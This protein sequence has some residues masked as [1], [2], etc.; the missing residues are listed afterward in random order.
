MKRAAYL[1]I[2]ILIALL[3]LGLA[4]CG[5]MGAAV[6]AEFADERLKTVYEIDENIDFEYISLNIVYEKGEKRKVVERGEITGFDTSVCG[7]KTLRAE[8][9][10]VEATWEYEVVYAKELNRT[11]NTAARVRLEQEPYPTGTRRAVAVDKADL[12][13]ISAIM[14]TINADKDF[15][16]RDFT[17]FTAEPTDGYLCKLYYID[18]KT[19]RVLIYATGDTGSD[20]LFKF[21]LLGVSDCATRLTEIDASDGENDYYL[22]ETEEV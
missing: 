18:S 9:D 22:P 13:K 5:D 15:A 14:F 4:A 17:R 8:C 10:G 21:G 6:G 19:V 1:S 11:V 2:I 20:T 16:D 3:A 12:N 7:K